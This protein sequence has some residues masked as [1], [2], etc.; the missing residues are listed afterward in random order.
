MV[1]H[2]QHPVGVRV[3]AL[4][5]VRDRVALVHA[6]AHRQSELRR[7]RDPGLLV[8]AAGEHGVELLAPIERVDD[9]GLLVERDAVDRDERVAQLQRAWRG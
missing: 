3:A 8:D 2:L 6:D 7:D 4:D 9:R 1:V 5:H